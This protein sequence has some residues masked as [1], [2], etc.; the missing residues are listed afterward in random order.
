MV[1]N[2]PA[3]AR[4]MRDVDSAP[5]FGRSPEE[6]NGNPLQYSFLLGKSHGQGGLAG[7]SPRGCKRIGHDLA[8]KQQQLNFIESFNCFQQF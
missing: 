3:N 4:D 6:G 8:S 2:L 7:Y 5:G 1:K